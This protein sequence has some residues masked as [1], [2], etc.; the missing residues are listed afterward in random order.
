MKCESIRNRILLAQSG[1]LSWFGRASLAEH[2]RACPDCRQFQAALRQSAEALRAAPVPAVSPKVLE[3]I[4]LFARKQASHS[5]LI[6][7]RPSRA[8]LAAILRPAII[9]S[10]LG[11]LLLTGFWLTIRPAMNQLLQ[12]A[13]PTVVVQDWDMAA[14]DTQIDDL[15]DRLDIAAADEE[16]PATD[17]DDLDSIARELLELEGQQI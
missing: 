16:T 11:I 10:A 17:S 1:E 4:R 3:Q 12:A 15:N 9:Y 5:E 2:L 13:A 8:P 14:I 7:L 6:H